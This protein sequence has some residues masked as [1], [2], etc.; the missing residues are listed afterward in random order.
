M[1][2][3][4]RKT[5][6]RQSCERRSNRSRFDSVTYRYDFALWQIVCLLVEDRSGPDRFDVGFCD[7]LDIRLRP[8]LN[9]IVVLSHAA[10]WIGSGSAWRREIL[11]DS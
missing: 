9:F 2:A 3:H 5:C 4:A 7:N 6:F 11:D 1:L 8:Y 10:A